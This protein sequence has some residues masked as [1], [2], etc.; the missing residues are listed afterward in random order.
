MH[1]E[2]LQICLGVTRSS[3]DERQNC[4]FVNRGHD[5][6]PNIAEKRRVVSTS[7]ER[8]ERGERRKTDYAKTL[9]YFAN[10]SMVLM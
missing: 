5:L 4:G 10:V 1:E 3:L 9:S 7:Q 6:I 2:N 8:V